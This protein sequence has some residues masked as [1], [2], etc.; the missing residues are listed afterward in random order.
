MRRLRLEDLVLAFTAADL[1]I[2]AG[3]LLA[4]HV[5]PLA[6]LIVVAGAAGF[7]LF[8]RTQRE[9]ALWLLVVAAVIVPVAALIAIRPPEAPV[10]DSVLL[11]D[12]AAGRLLH[13]ADP[14]GHDYVDDEA[15]RAFWLPE[16][17]V[18]PLLAHFP[19]PPGMILLA[20][21]M[22]LL[23]VSVAWLWPPALLV[24]ALAARAAAGRPGLAAAGLS[25]LLL[26]D[27]LALFNDA[28]FLA[29]G[30]G[31]W[32]LMRR[33]RALEAGALAGLA[34]CCK[35]PALVLAPPLLWLAW[36]RGRPALARFLAGGAG[37][38]A[39]VTG[40]FLAWNA[41]AF[42]AD[43]ATYF[44]GSGVDSFPI[45]GPGLAGLL[46]AAGQL[47]SRWAAFPSALIQVPVL[48]AVVV[49]GWR[50]LGGHLWLWAALV[51]TALFGLGRT[52]APNYVSVV[53]ILL[54]LE[55]A[56]ALDPRP[57]DPRIE[58]AVDRPARDAGVEGAA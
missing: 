47:S 12:A 42:I 49:I 1:L 18:N 13:G 10:Q 46:L 27:G 58:R 6:G 20:L 33:G 22:R 14:Y 16:I 23:G 9:A 53:G 50:R 8:H 25:P 17:P 40:P 37:A 45:R 7:V 34:L 31:A 38:V 29:A 39:L 43:T 11:T 55:V 15:L 30:L 28:F 51:G 5:W 41:G 19:Y 36:R 35:Q 4:A 21:P 57:G 54:S 56:S 52:L 2:G 3:V 26:L 48:G 32:A 24:L 44:Y